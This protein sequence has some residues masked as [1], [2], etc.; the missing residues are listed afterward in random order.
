MARIKLER[1]SSELEQ[2]LM[3]AKRQLG[4]ESTRLTTASELNSFGQ[5]Q[6]DSLKGR[7]AAE[8]ECRP[9]PPA[10]ALRASTSN[11][12]SCSQRSSHMHSPPSLSPLCLPTENARITSDVARLARETELQHIRVA[13]SAESSTVKALSEQRALLVLEVE[14]TRAGNEDH[15]ATIRS[16]EAILATTKSTLKATQASLQLETTQRIEQ[17]DWRRTC[18][19][20]M[21]SIA[22]KLQGDLQQRAEG[23]STSAFSGTD[24]VINALTSGSRQASVPLDGITSA[25]IALHDRAVAQ[26]DYYLAGRAGSN[27]AVD[28]IREEMT[29]TKVSCEVDLRRL[30]STLEAEVGKTERA[31][32]KAQVDGGELGALRAANLTLTGQVQQSVQECDGLTRQKGEA[33]ARREEAVSR[34]TRELATMSTT[35]ELLNGELNKVKTTNAQIAK[36]KKEIAASTDSLKEEVEKKSENLTQ[37]GKRADALQEQLAQTM[38]EVRILTVDNRKMEATASELTREIQHKAQEVIQHKEQE[39]RLLEENRRIMLEFQASEEMRKR[40][41]G[42]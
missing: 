10:C 36:E 35:K 2:Q 17:E 37:M 33:E 39:G 31:A 9:V 4:E 41:A 13:L 7:L 3:A 16:L 12:R 11:A 40:L 24:A 29:A 32:A 23:V 14:E 21:Q 20:S 25:L 30:K 26:V 18:E 22:H 1:V 15:S 6:V 27:T 8:G 5:G 42:M 19:R 38:D 28:A 34:L